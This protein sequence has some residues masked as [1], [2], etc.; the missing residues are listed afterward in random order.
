MYE[1]DKA[2]F[3]E[4]LLEQR[5][6][7]KYTQKELAQ[8]LFVSDKAVSKWERGISMPD[9]S[10]LI[11]LADILDVTVTELLEGEALEK[12]RELD[13]DQVE[14]L[15]KKALTFSEETPE[16]QRRKKK[17][18]GLIYGLSCLCFGLE[19]KKNCLLIMTRIR[20]VTI[21]TGDFN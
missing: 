8:K 4:F 5:R 18:H 21:A 6:A 13:A 19:S 12:E 3:G 20:S 11:P 2:R 16:S 17:K 14:E 9:I 15:V 7:K 1:I 10:L